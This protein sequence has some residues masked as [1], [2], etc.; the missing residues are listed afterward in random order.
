MSGSRKYIPI[1]SVAASAA[2]LATPGGGKVVITGDDGFTRPYVNAGGF[3]VLRYRPS[4]AES[5]RVAATAS[6][7]A[8]TSYSFYI[9]QDLRDTNDVTIPTR[10]LISYT[11]GA[12]APSASAFGT[13]LTAVVNGKISDNG[14]SATA[15]AY[16]SGN[17]GVDITGSS[18][19]STFKISQE[20]NLTTTS[21]L[22]SATSSGNASYSG[23]AITVLHNDTSDIVVGGQVK[24]DGW[25][26]VA[27]IN[28]ADA[29]EGV[30]LPVTAVTT[31]TSF[32]LLA[33]T[34][35]GSIGTATLDFEVIAQDARGLGSAYIAD[36]ITAGGNPSVSVST[37]GL[38]HEVII[39][40]K[41]PS[42]Q[43]QNTADFR[44]YEKHF[45]IES[46]DT[47]AAD[48]LDRINEVK[49]YLDASGNFDPLLLV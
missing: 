40:G 33:E 11:T 10:V 16:T 45:L 21:L 2:D 19:N 20:V 15:V 29:S 4:V 22:Q 47:D 13:A 25:G 5:K 48:L 12:S 7:A 41:E 26:G 23:L 30:T 49:D 24:I 42:G 35:S 38:Y 31:N 43:S 39:S 9:E 36:G 27:I 28:G 37:S 14:L 3:T 17:G 6:P 18:T 34:I 44:P 1:N 8:N 32:V 46:T